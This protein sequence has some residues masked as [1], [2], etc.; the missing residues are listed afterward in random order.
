MQQEPI[1]AVYMIQRDCSESYPIYRAFVLLPEATE[2]EEMLG[3]WE[4]VRELQEEVEGRVPGVERL[5][6][7]T[8]AEAVAVRQTHTEE[9]VALLSQESDLPGIDLTKRLVYASTARPWSNFFIAESYAVPCI[10]GV[11]IHG[12]HV[13]SYVTVPHLLDKS[14]VDH[15]DLTFISRPAPATEEE[16]VIHASHA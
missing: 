11:R 2:A 3:P 6:S 15:F 7:E 4:N 16:E 8:F 1:K 5:N 12:W 10:T 9:M 13:H 14:Q